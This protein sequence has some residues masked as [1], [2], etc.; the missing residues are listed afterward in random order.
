MHARLEGSS[1][2]FTGKRHPVNILLVLARILL[3]A[4]VS[5]NLQIALPQLAKAAD[6]S[7]LPH[8]QPGQQVM[9]II[10]NFGFSLGGMMPIWESE[11]LKYQPGIQFDDK[12]PS[13]D[14]AIAGLI[15]GVSDIGP[16]GRELTL[17]EHLMFYETFHH[18]PAAIT[19]AT[20][21]YDAE[22][23]SCGLVIYVH[24]D[25]PISKLTMKQL[26][27]IFGAERSGAYR[28]F[29]WMLESA[30]TA[31]DDIR[32]W[33]Q[34]GLIGEWAGKPIHTYGH[35]PSGTANFFQ[36]KVLGGGDKWNPNYREYVES[37]SKM[38]SDTDSAQMGGIQHMLADELANDKYGIAWTIIPQARKIA[39]IKPVA[40]AAEESGPFVEPSKETFQDRTYPLTRAIY[41]YLSRAPGK[42]IDPKLKEFIHFVLS[43]EGQQALENHGKYLPLTAS[44][45]TAQLSELERK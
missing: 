34:L 17:V 10:R 20:G 22:G 15:S 25:N 18:Y 1:I 35:A 29:K 43:R 32:T 28:G 41:F 9:G 27:G 23:A 24:K 38:I 16:Q 7:N 42:Q 2:N 11:F 33:D 19:V 44:I 26:D 3:A 36:L 6:L 39:N 13:G 8:Y 45:A 14:A 37:N 4:C 12:F 5:A 30:R 40:L 31:K 21:A